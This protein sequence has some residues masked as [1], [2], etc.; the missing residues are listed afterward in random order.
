MINLF[1]YDLVL[2]LNGVC[3]KTWFLIPSSAFNEARGYPM[4]R[5]NYLQ[6][7]KTKTPKV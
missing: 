1:S 3:I 4:E 6:D 5:D 2:S 7:L